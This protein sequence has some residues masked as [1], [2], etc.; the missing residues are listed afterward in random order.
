MQDFQ[1][2]DDDYR[3]GSPGPEEID[4]RESSREGE[5]F[6]DTKLC[7]NYER[8]V[9]SYTLPDGIIVNQQ[10]RYD[11]LSP[12]PGADRPAKQ[13]RPR[14]P[15]FPGINLIEDTQHELTNQDCV[16]GPGPRRVIYNWPAIVKAGP[17][18][19]VFV[20]MG[21]KNAQDLIDRKL[22]ATT[23]ISGK[24]TDEC[25]GALAGFE[26]FILED[27]DAKG[28]E[29]AAKAQALLSAVAKSTRIVTAAHLWRHLPPE[30][31]EKKPE[32]TADVSNWLELDGDAS[33][34]IEICREVRAE[35]E[36]A[37][38][39]H[40]FVAAK[41]ISLWDFLYGRHLLRG[42]VSLTAGVSGTGK[43]SKSIAE[44]L[45]MTTGKPIL[46][47]QPHN[48]LLRVLLINLEDNR[49]TLDKRIAAAMK[50]HGLSPGD[51]GDRLTTIAK[52]ELKFK[53]AALARGVFKPNEAAVRNLIEF[54]REKKFD[55]V[56]IDPL[57]RSHRVPE[58]D[59]VTMGEVI[60]LYEDVAFEANCGIHLWHHVRKGN[61]SGTTIESVRGASAIVDAPRSCELL[62][63]MT[64]DE[65]KKFGVPI[66]RR[67][68]YFRSFS[69]MA[70]FAPPSDHSDW[71]ELVR[72]DLENGF[73]GDSVGVV[74]RWIPPDAR[75]LPLSAEEVMK[76]RAA[77]G[78]APIWREDV[79]AAMWVGKAVA[80][81]VN[82]S[83]D[84]DR[85]A[86]RALVGR[87]LS[88]GVLKTV[89]ER[90]PKRREETLFV[91]V[92]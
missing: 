33:K 14:R 28:R 62:E 29:Q 92:A 80:P 90:N 85:V 31:A 67:K 30:H 8:T 53:V 75:E 70:N 73:P 40:V 35:D 10:C 19:P 36:I 46:K 88:T 25:V 65:A 78:V 9:Y 86:V 21:E 26:L 52:Y 74:A 79:R 71:F 64:E 55:V 4:R 69:G 22:L 84:N 5:K 56:S 60:E 11:D 63:R 32:E 77:V 27:N 57:R 15:L 61:G 41:D 43:S 16:F 47:V 54:A 83:A 81:V 39:P 13:F 58:N 24:W 34:L 50:H 51:V 49:N 1:D 76:I 23:V 18:G 45:A 42:E 87:L 91:V 3:R 82:L 7:E 6:D 38:E 72:V 66:E 44:A 20:C 89:K 68:F 37:A 2:D 12:I 17:P 48:A 59:N